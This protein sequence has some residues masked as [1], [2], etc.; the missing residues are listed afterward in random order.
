M[1]IYLE[2]I[3]LKEKELLQIAEERNQT[4]ASLRNSEPTPI[5]IDHQ[6]KWLASMSESDRYYF[7]YDTNYGSGF[8]EEFLGYCGLDKISLVNRTAEISLLICENYQKLGYGKKAIKLLLEKGFHDFH[9]NC[10]YGECY[11]ST[12]NWKFWLNCGFVQDGVLQERKFWKNKFYHAMSF[13]MTRDIWF[14]QSMK[15]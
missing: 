15:G 6:K 2:P 5:N 10:I 1:T 13:S 12:E 7:I 11:Y 3:S 4:L 8:K 14:K 9:L